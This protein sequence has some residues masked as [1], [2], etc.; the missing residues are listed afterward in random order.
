M[1]LATTNQ[2]LTETW[3]ASQCY[4][5]NPNT[6]PQSLLIK[7]SLAT[8]FY[9]TFPPYSVTC[10]SSGLLTSVS[11]K[12]LFKHNP[13]DDCSSIGALAESNVKPLFLHQEAPFEVPVMLDWEQHSV[14]LHRLYMKENKT[15]KEMMQYMESNHGFKAT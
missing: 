6:E 13:L 10:C 9:L 11:V 2:R 1:I 3:E 8:T 12:H 14:V 7:G 5:H 15:L 4:V